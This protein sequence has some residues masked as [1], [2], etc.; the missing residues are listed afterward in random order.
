LYVFAGPV[1]KILAPGFDDATVNFS[2]YLFQLGFVR[3]NAVVAATFFTQYLNNK[4][5]FYPPMI[6]ASIGTIATVGYLLVAGSA[7]NVATFMVVTVLGDIM[8]VLWMFPALW[9]RGFKFRLYWDLKDSNLGLFFSLSFPATANYLVQ[10]IGIIITRALASQL[11]VGSISALSYANSIVMMLNMTV[12]LSIATAIFPRLAEALSFGQMGKAIAFFRQGIFLACVLLIPAAVGLIILAQPIST[13]LFER[14]LFTTEN[15]VMTASA[16][17]GYSIGILAYA[18]YELASRFF[19]S[20][21]DTKTPMMTAYAGVVVMII[22]SFLLYKP[23]KL[24]GLSLAASLMYIVMATMLLAIIHKR[25]ARIFDKKLLANFLR[26]I[27]ATSIMGIV[28]FWVRDMNIISPTVGI[29]D[30]TVKI[31]CAIFVYG[32]SIALLLVSTR[33]NG[34]NIQKEG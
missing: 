28:L 33:N 19:N 34:D 25:Y 24:L 12:S 10:Q 15:S 11:P 8:A 26:V 23:L 9:Q 32:V 1:I 27:V 6:A 18:Y 3:I 29:L 5:C 22:L 20:M 14:G 31:I 2:V 30:L 17:S 4:Y 16:L 13:V 7:A 21:K